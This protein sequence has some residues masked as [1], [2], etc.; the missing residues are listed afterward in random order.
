MKI[1]KAHGRYSRVAIFGPTALAQYVAEQKLAIPSYDVLT[2]RESE[3]MIEILADH[4]KVKLP[5][6]TWRAKT[7]RGCVK[8]VALVDNPS[9]KRHIVCIGPDV[10]RGQTNSI[11]HEFAHVLHIARGDI[12]R[13]H[14]PEF[15]SILWEVVK[16][17]H[18]DPNLYAWK[19]EYS[20]IAKKA[21]QW[22]AQGEYV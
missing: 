11:L 12:G 15:Q 22:L 10:W 7:R 20:Y 9:L 21:V 8:P 16:G 17:W 4:Y 2:R 3:R 18:G 1:P 14:G 6:M 19:Q 5:E 13:A